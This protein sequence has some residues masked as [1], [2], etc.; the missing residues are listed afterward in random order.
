MH[1]FF[2]FI[3]ATYNRKVLTAETVDC[4]L[5]QHFTNFELILVDD[6][7]TDGSF[8]YLT[9]RYRNDTRVKIIYQENA[10][11]GA[12]RNN[13]IRHA[14]GEYLVFVD[15]DDLIDTNHLETLHRYILQES[16]PNFL[17]CK[18]DLVRNE[19][20]IPTKLQQFN[21]GYYDY[22][23]LLNG[24]LLGMY[25]CVKRTNPNLILFEEN[26]EYAILEDWMFHFI[27]LKNDKIF[28]IDSITYHINDHV[29][30][31]MQSSYQV[32]SSKIKLAAQWIIE[33]A[34]LNNAESTELVAFAHYFA[35][36]H[37]Y[38][39]NA[40]KD[41]RRELYQAIR[42]KGI[43]LPYLLLWTKCFLGRRLIVQIKQLI[44]K[45]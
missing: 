28:L 32:L 16:F 29:E 6:G 23:L 15:S 25:S 22:R 12:A 19:K 42:L 21:Q 20:S 1:P 35:A 36:I 31:S 18:F 39:E 41:A 17:S 44:G 34:N 9:N 27:N 30:R 14:S 7:S 5:K 26:R 45:A 38:A 37:A 2:S 40:L 24:N 33:K 8:E 13:G 4:M 10:E 43:T 3:T 11:R